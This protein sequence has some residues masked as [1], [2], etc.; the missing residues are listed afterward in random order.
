MI[1]VV[2]ERQLKIVNFLRENQFASI[3]DL[4]SL[5][6]YSEA[7]IKRDLIELEKKGLIRRTRGGAF[8]IDNRKVDV[9]FL[10]K[11]TELNENSA[12]QRIA[13]SVQKLIKDDMIIFLDSSSTCLH[14]AKS[15]SRFDGLQVITNGVLTAALLSEYTTAHVLVLGGAI[16]SKR[17]TI[18]GSKA[19]ND[20]L[21]YNADI[22]IMSCRGID[23]ENGTSETHEGEALIKKAFRKQSKKTIILATSDKFNQKFMHQSLTCHEIDVLVTNSL[24]PKE[25]K[26]KL[27]MH[28]IKYITTN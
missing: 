23:F 4:A 15:L 16:V 6:N 5:V 18:N 14:L 24:L 22:A 20:A 19:Y 8:L 27:D 1:S 13:D 2:E 3:V 10:M 25:A 21:S 9:P 7:T 12:K 11:L 26:M 28:E 17:M